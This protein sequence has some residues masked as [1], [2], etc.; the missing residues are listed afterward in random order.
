MERQQPG[1]MDTT[2]ASNKRYSDYANPYGHPNVTSALISRH[3]NDKPSSSLGVKVPV[4]MHEGS[5]PRDHLAK[6]HK[7][8]FLENWSRSVPESSHLGHQGF[9]GVHERGES[10][11]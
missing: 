7:H 3:Q 6:Q 2:Q 11:D 10:P 1:L 9:D 8:Y 5:F 4:S